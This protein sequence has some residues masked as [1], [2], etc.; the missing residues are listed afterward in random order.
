MDTNEI[1]EAINQEIH[2]LETAKA[3]LTGGGPAIEAAS[4]RKI[5][6]AARRK[7]GAAQKGEMGEGE[8]GPEVELG[9]A[10]L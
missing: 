9:R 4:R 8:K 2:R 3:L 1:I 6:A 5:G 10:K 7:I